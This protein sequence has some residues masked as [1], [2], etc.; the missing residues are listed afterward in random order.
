M[1]CKQ[2]SAVF[3]KMKVRMSRKSSVLRHCCAIWKCSVSIAVH[4]QLTCEN[5][6]IPTFRCFSACSAPYPAFLKLKLL[7][8]VQQLSQSAS[9]SYSMLLNAVLIN[10]N[11][12]TEFQHQFYKYFFLLRYK[13]DFFGF[14]ELRFCFQKANKGEIAICFWRTSLT[15]KILVN[16]YHK[17]KYLSMS[18]C[19]YSVPRVQIQ[20]DF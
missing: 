5:I 14:K 3:G 17:L 6:L 9:G 2:P 18:V 20:P 19:W 16:F 11:K 13:L 4:Y 10:T 8:T 15:C 1:L 7:F 12:S